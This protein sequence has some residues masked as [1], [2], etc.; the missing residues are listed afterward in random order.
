VPQETARRALS[1]EWFEHAIRFGHAAKGAV[2]GGIGF[3]AAR[4]ALGS[5]DE[6]PDFAGALE[7]LADKPLDVL[8]L[9][10]MAFGLLAYSAWRFAYGIADLEKAGKGVSGWLKRGTMIAVGLTYLGFAAYAVALLA[11]MRRGDVGIESETATVLQWPLGEWIVG[12][13][14]LGVLVAGLFELFVAFTARYRKEFS[15]VRLA[16]WEKGIVHVAGWWGHAARGT[17][18]VAAGYF[19]IRSAVQYD[20]DEARGFSDTLRELG[21]GE[22]GDVILLF[23]AAG[24]IAFGIYSV[25]LAIHR[26]V[27]DES[28]EPEERL[29]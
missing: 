29:P 18:Y 3:L 1:N 20:P 8:F 7:S 15:H 24:L 2:F 12:A 13:V 6:T 23:I 28:G 10:V 25:M 4:L 16:R 26:H 11:G 22:W 19:G 9:G 21:S 5:R 14:G 27:P 17:I